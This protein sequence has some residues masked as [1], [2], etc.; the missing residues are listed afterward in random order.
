MKAFRYLPSL[1]LLSACSL[2]PSYHRP[3]M[4]IGDIYRFEPLNSSSYVN[5][6]WWKRFQD[7][8]L[9]HMIE[10]ALENNQDL[11]VATARVL[12]FLSKYRIVFSQF[13]PEID[14]SGMA[15]R[16][17]LPISKDFDITTLGVP[18]YNNTYRLLFQ[19]SYELDFW[20]KIR[21]S[22]EAAKAIYLSET[23]ARETVVLSLISAVATSYFL[24]KQFHEQLEISKL[25]YE[26]RKKS[27][28]IASLR[29]KGGLVSELD[30]K[31]AESEAL[32][33]EV[34]IRNFELFLAKQEDL[35]SILLGKPPGPIARGP[36]LRDLSMPNWLSVGLPADLLTN[37]PDILQAEEKIK[38]ANAEVGVARAAFLPAFN[39]TGFLG[40]T[41]SETK[42]LFSSM[43]NFWDIAL[44]AFEPLFTGFRRTNQLS[45]KEALFLQALHS[46]QQ[47][48]L[49]A[50][51]EVSD[52]LIA[53]EKAKEKFQIQTERVASLQEYLKLANL[54]Y[55][56]GQNDYLTVLDAE[57]SLF[58]AELERSKTE[59][60]LF[61][62]LVSL[63]KAL[64]QGWN[65]DECAEA[66]TQEPSKEPF[67][68]GPLEKTIHRDNTK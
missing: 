58:L 52:A 36:K 39:L 56:N 65:V 61:L 21:N 2:K 37:R 32:V 50:L 48:V 46:Y 14:T 20:G 57:K 35:L 19:F 33:A 60:D 10:E 28:D 31:Q 30:V 47:T 64:G 16:Y 51:Q 3:E 38:A 63:F 1:L 11:Q 44:N 4:A 26:S 27:W 9:E 42:T 13:F 15:D 22:A 29:F 23:Y 53:H 7:P 66:E 68:V 45:E 17:K 34:Q 25:T 24:I 55:F 8:H 62:S 41:A 43:G 18:R 59:G 67:F 6:A 49:N 12:E 54:R 40:Q 5:Q